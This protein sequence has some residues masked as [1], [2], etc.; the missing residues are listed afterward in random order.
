[1]KYLFRFSKLCNE[2]IFKIKKNAGKKCILLFK[3]KM[4]EQTPLKVI[5]QSKDISEY[6]IFNPFLETV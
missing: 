2:A 4:I 5:Y 6:E 3:K 1:M